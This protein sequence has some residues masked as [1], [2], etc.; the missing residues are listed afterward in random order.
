MTAVE[1]RTTGPLSTIQDLG[2]PGYAHVGVPRSGAADRTSAA[3][4]NRL[5]GNQDRAAVIES[6]WGGL[7]VVAHTPA[8]VAVTGAETTVS[9]D[10]VASG[11]GVALAVRPGQVISVGPPR[12]GVRNYLAVRGGFDVAMVL[13]SRSTDTLSGLGPAPLVVGDRLVV[14]S[15]AGAWPAAVDAPISRPGGAFDLDVT[16]GPRSDRVARPADLLVG[17]WVVTPD[18]DRVGV[19]LDRA[20][21]SSEPLLTHRADVDELLSEGVAHG[22]IQVP[23][24][25]RPVAFLADHPVTGGYPV[26]AVLTAASLAHV[27]QLRAGDRVQ[28]RAR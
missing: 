22:S 9:V 24:N 27:A 15:D 7:Q 12:S 16:D 8:L 25:G 6:T 17:R 1:I 11:L 5:V 3:L 2:R 4:A 19:R 20:P 13:G 21:D 14:G 26:I 23:P 10:G 28:F 18:A